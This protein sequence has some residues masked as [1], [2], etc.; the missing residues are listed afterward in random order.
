MKPTFILGMG[1]QKAGSSWLHKTIS[2]HDSVNM[3]F[4]KEYHI[5][6]YVYSDLCKVFKAPTTQPDNPVD[7]LRRMMQNSPQI[8]A[9]Y[10]QGLI[11]SKVHVTGD[12]TPSY[13]MVSQSGL[14]DIFHTLTY[15]GFDVK[16][17]F[18]MRDPIE[19]LWSAVRMEQR[20]RLQRG[21]KIDENF[22]NLRILEYMKND[23]H[24]ARSDYVSTVQNIQAVFPK[25]AIYFEMYENLFSQKSI[26]RLSDFLGFTLKNVD[27]MEHVNASP[28]STR[29]RETTEKL[30]Q[31]LAPQYEF[32]KNQFPLSQK[33]WKH[34][35]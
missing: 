27:L 29:S 33:L 3:G 31:L 28:N 32:C 13:S 24:L 7:A 25:N 21:E 35:P 10:F 18:L 22:T 23:A 4:M 11:S 5:W 20:N 6:D 19:R 9:E 8:Y 15:A 30:Q 2:N 12:I 34:M 1:A 26:Q 14:E 16:V 17:I